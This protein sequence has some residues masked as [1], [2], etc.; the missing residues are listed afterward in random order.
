MSP[1]IYL[2]DTGALDGFPPDLD[3]RSTKN[4]SRGSADIQANL[5]RGLAYL[6]ARRH[7]ILTVLS[8][9]DFPIDETPMERTV[10]CLLPP[11]FRTAR[12][13]VMYTTDSPEQ[14][15]KASA[16]PN[17]GFLKSEYWG[18]SADPLL[19][20]AMLGF[21]DVSLGSMARAD[22]GVATA[23]DLEFEAIPVP[24]S[25]KADAF[26]HHVSI[27]FIPEATLEI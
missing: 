3:G 11:Y 19:Q 20:F 15:L 9:P 10:R 12:V 4:H 23:I 14:R 1:V 27:E 21:I 5:E 2:A 8:T 22:Y 24:N 17:G 13:H 25:G 26:L 6:V 18:G 7:P 16:G